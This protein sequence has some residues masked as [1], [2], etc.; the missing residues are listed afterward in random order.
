MCNEGMRTAP[1]LGPC[2]VV[3]NDVRYAREE[4]LFAAMREVERLQVIAAAAAEL[5][6]EHPFGSL[7]QRAFYRLRE[8][9]RDA[10]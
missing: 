5:V 1:D 8:V 7:D 9:L 6:V 10:N 2:E 4:T 3:V